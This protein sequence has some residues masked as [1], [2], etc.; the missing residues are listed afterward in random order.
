MQHGGIS[1]QRRG[2]GRANPQFACLYGGEAPLVRV[3][4]R[5]RPLASPVHSPRWGEHVHVWR[6]LARKEHN[7]VARRL[8]RGH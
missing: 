3:K 2:F 4:P 6:L 1:H 7:N 8:Q 5:I